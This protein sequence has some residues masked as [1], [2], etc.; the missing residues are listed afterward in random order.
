M[1]V[2]IQNLDLL[3]HC[4]Q[5]FQWRHQPKKRWVL[6]PNLN[7]VSL[8][9]E[10]L[11]FEKLYNIL[12]MENDLIYSINFSTAFAL[13]SFRRGLNRLWELQ[14]TSNLFGTPCGNKTSH[15][16]GLLRDQFSHVTLK[17]G[18]RCLTTSNRSIVQC[19]QHDE[20][21]TILST[22]KARQRR[23][24]PM[25]MT[26]RSP[27]R[28]YCMDALTHYCSAALHDEVAKDIISWERPKW[29]FTQRQIDTLGPCYAI[30][31]GH[32]HGRWADVFQT[33]SNRLC[34]L[35]GDYQILVDSIC[36]PRCRQSRCLSVT[37]PDYY[38][39]R[40]ISRQCVAHASSSWGNYEPSNVKW[41]QT[42]PKTIAQAFVGGWVTTATVYLWCQW[43]S[44]R[45]LQSAQNVGAH[46]MTGKCKYNH[47]TSKLGIQWLSSK[48]KIQILIT[49]KIAT[50]MNWFFNGL[51]HPSQAVDCIAISFFEAWVETVSICPLISRTKTM[52]FVIR[53]FKV[54]LLI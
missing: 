36:Q 38:H 46:F 25:L 44:L 49:F 31:K 40:I 1:R 42:A 17:Y 20:F 54:P 23:C 3:K 28:W 12:C 39:H 37:K 11:A 14:V 7:Y 45:C 30:C 13:K 34:Q 32:V 33:R 35:H 51:A 29:R 27:C 24:T 50:L 19:S 5:W 18:L 52:T 9:F 16:S 6:P 8:V 43:R 48:T 22:G 4:T 10:W 2:E 26:H 15:C 21:A 53:L 41:Q 47:M